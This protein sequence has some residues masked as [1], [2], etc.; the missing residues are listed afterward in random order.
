MTSAFPTPTPFSEE[1]MTLRDYFAAKAMQSIIAK[2]PFKFKNVTHQEI[3]E[4]TVSLAYGAYCYADAML[5]ER[6]NSE[7]IKD[8]EIAELRK[9]YDDLNAEY[10]AYCTNQG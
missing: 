8:K 1:G 9:M 2:E 3:A 6:G 4:A 7:S 10:Q 5:A